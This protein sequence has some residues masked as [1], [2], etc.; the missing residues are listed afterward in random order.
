MGDTFDCQH[1]GILGRDFWE[2]KK[3]TINYCD[4]TVTMDEVMLDFD[5]KTDRVAS[6]SCKLTLTA[7]TKP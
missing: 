4:P 3:V 1:D 2:S 6:K 7:R 5:D